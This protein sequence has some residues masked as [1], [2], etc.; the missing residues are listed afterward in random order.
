LK[1]LTFIIKRGFRE[2]SKLYQLNPDVIQDVNQK[3]KDNTNQTFFE[4]R[5]N[6]I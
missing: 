4:K 1:R 5:E 3:M 6:F 2:F